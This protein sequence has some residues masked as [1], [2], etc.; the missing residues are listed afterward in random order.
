M[1]EFTLV[2]MLVRLQM[3]LHRLAHIRWQRDCFSQLQYIA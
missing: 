2:T 1:H 3:E